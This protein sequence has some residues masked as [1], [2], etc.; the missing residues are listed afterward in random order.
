M[1]DSLTDDLVSQLREYADDFVDGHATHRMLVG[2]A[3]EIER[4]RTEVDDLN[5][6][7]A[8][9]DKALCAITMNLHEP[10]SAKAAQLV[11]DKHA[12]GSHD[13]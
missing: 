13:H 1:T 11:L 4:L 10:E 6:V 3:A 2:A 5:T 8:D 12:R 9:Y 7:G